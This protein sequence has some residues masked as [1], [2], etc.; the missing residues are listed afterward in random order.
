LAFFARLPRCLIGMEACATAHDGARQLIKLGHEVRLPARRRQGLG[1]PELATA[2]AAPGHGNALAP[3]GSGAR[4]APCALSPTIE[5]NHLEIAGAERTGGSTHAKDP[6]AGRQPHQSPP[7]AAV[8]VTIS[9]SAG[10]STS[11]GRPDSDAG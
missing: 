2:T 7:S 8:P 4:R 6:D 5:C 9:R 11:P 3:R 10:A 1:A